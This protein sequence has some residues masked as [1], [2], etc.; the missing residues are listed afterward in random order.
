MRPGALAGATRNPSWCARIAILCAAKCCFVPFLR[1]HN[2]SMEKPTGRAKSANMR[3]DYVELRLGSFEKRTLQDAAKLAGMP[4]S[5]WVRAR[6]RQAAIKEPEDAA[7]PIAFL[8]QMSQGEV[9]AE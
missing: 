8:K 3:D 7:M 2:V 5:T 6:L 9:S 1:V 4:T